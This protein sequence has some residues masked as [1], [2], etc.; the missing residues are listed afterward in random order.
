MRQELDA[1]FLDDGFQCSS[2]SRKFLNASQMKHQRRSDASFSALQRA[3]NFSM[4][5]SYRAH[6]DAASF[7]ALQRA[8][9]FSIPAGG[10][11]VSPAREFQCS[12]ASRKFLNSYCY[13]ASIPPARRFSALQRAENFSIAAELPVR[14]IPALG[15][16]CSSASRKFLNPKR[17]RCPTRPVEFQCSS[18]SR[19]FLNPVY[20]AKE[21][22]CLFVSVLFSEPKISQ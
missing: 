13:I 6:I 20:L 19:K 17:V 16:Q 14:I 8:E 7:S 9:N 5:G 12:S 15:F 3:E 11:D 10:V 21:M 4:S 22:H 18:A 1:E 2:A